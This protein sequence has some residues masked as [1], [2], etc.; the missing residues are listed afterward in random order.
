[1]AVPKKWYQFL[2]WLRVHF[3]TRQKIN[4]LAVV[5]G[6]A[7]GI[8]AV[9]L[10]NLVHIIAYWLQNLNG[11]LNL[12]YLYL[13]YPIIGIFLALM[14][15]KYVI[16][17]PSGHGVPGILFA[18]SQKKGNIEKHNMFSSIIT[19]SLTV[20]FGGSVGLE[21]PIVSTGAALGSNIG[22][23]FHLSYRQIRLMIG[24]A[25]AGA[26][27]SIFNAPIAGIIFSLEILMLDL[28][29]YALIPLLISSVS[30]IL[31][32]YLIIGNDALY[33]LAVTSGFSIGHIPFYIE[34]GVLCGF[35]SAYFSLVY[36]KMSRIFDK[37]SMYKRLLIGGGILGLLIFLF[38]SL[39]GEGYK[40]VNLCLANDISH[41]FSRSIFAYFSDNTIAIMVILLA[42]IL[43]KAIATSAT[44]GAG[45]VGGIFAPSLF[46][47]AHLGVLFAIL[48][49][50]TGLGN[51]SVSNFALIGMAGVMSGIMY[52]PL[53]A[54][55]LI[56]EVSGGYAL[57]LPLMIASAS[58]YLM[59]VYFSPNSVYTSQL[60]EQSLLLTHDKDKSTQRL[61][62][63]DSLIEK[64]FTTVTPD[65]T[66]GELIKTITNSK[67]NIFP[68]IDK[69]EF[70]GIVFL[71]DVRHL[72]LNQ[73]LY[74][75]V[76]VS[77]VMYMPSPIV[78]IT[79]NMESVVK[80]FQ[81]SSHYNL[82]VLDEKGKYIGFVS[83]A[84]T[85]STYQKLLSDISEE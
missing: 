49:N 67:R 35:V 68:V 58:S 18:L 56:A 44:F 77:D 62:K 85:F 50:Y 11:L 31:T 7:S 78:K 1:M 34:L 30:A 54:I 24:C 84:N 12:N 25:S 26:V 2:Q 17:K 28:T 60:A 8:A 46:I 6:L 5:V 48:I 43:F 82:P 69:N 27:A 64:N 63:I 59:V 39:Y 80:K 21:G 75:I 71:D 40:E 76:T 23:A 3:S 36:K 61:M 9:I 74:D 81:N 19:S 66:L 52:A 55:F 41:I 15:M 51:V 42:I 16:K 32:S 45:G 38:P 65:M 83:R 72:I 4:M 37:M 33:P 57:I 22:K 53:F 29:M 73:E 10:K 20:G 70:K 79:D 47:G 14:F 13:I